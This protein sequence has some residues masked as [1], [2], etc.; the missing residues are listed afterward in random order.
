L[1]I[2]SSLVQLMGGQL[3]VESRPGVGSTFSFNILLAEA[4]LPVPTS[5]LALSEPLHGLRVLVVDD[6]A[7]NRH[8][9][10]SMLLSW[11]MHPLVAADAVQARRTLEEARLSGA[12]P[13][14]ALIDAVMPGEDGFTLARSISEKPEFSGIKTILLSSA[15]TGLM[16]DFAASGAVVCLEKP[17]FQKDL[18]RA[19]GQ[20]LGYVV[21]TSPIGDLH[22]SEAGVAEKISR[23]LSILLAEDTPANQK[24]V[25][26]VLETRGHRLQI[27][28]NGHEA[29]ALVKHNEFDVILMDVEMP[30]VDGFQATATIR[31]MPDTRKSRVPI[32][33]MTA[34]AMPGDRERCL[35]GGMN[36][37]LTKPV[38]RVSL[39]RLVE[40]FVDSSAASYP[41]AAKVS[42]AVAS[43]LESEPAFELSEAIEKCFGRYDM[44]QKMVDCLFRDRQEILAEIEA[45]R[46]EADVGRI[47]KAA[48]RLKG[49]VFYLAAAPTVRTATAIERHGLAGELEAAV[50]L[51]PELQ[52][53]LLVLM[54]DLEEHR[55]ADQ[56]STS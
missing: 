18:L 43:P 56:T 44:F 35:A 52:E 28:H 14:V 34:H 11:S 30:E 31:A 7:T 42:P 10:K 36:A 15:G 45:G 25:E 37:Y 20:A 40:S 9:L 17:V 19:L 54:E 55:T 33:A 2:A 32:I 21:E 41:G 8:V 1:A 24:V 53:R 5:L 49:T 47:G 48:H 6:N 22:E 23:P 46:V 4:V 50:A 51:L 13:R 16:P 27:A 12:C 3:R 29:L 26:F 38:N 39:I